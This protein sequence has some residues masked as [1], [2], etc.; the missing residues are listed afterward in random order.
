MSATEKSCSAV[1][2][3]RFALSHWAA[4][5]TDE[6]LRKENRLYSLGIMHDSI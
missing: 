1:F 3:V 5:I 6:F 4:L 2:R